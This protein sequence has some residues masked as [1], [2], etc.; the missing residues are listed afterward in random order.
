ME[1]LNE[2]VRARLILRDQCCHLRIDR[3]SQGLKKREIT[4]HI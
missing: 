2:E 4:A 1:E 3:L